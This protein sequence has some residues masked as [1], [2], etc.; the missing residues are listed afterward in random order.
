LLNKAGKGRPNKERIKSIITDVST[1]QVL[2]NILIDASALFRK[3]VPSKGWLKTS[4]PKCRIFSIYFSLEN[5][6]PTITHRFIDM[7]DTWKKEI[8][9]ERDKILQRRPDLN[10]SERSGIAHLVNDY[11]LPWRMLCIGV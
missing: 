7:N 1:N 8:V 2:C 3:D 6:I 9:E 11:Q 5:S 10:S 4:F